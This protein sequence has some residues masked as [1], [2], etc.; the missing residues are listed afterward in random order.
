MTTAAGSIELALADIGAFLASRSERKIIQL[1]HVS[2]ESRHARILRGRIFHGKRESSLLS[3]IP[4]RLS[5]QN[6]LDGRLTDSFGRRKGECRV[7]ARKFLSRI[8]SGQ[9]RIRGESRAREAA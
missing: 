8:R 7:P 4:A 5:P 1:E 3:K 6:A 9:M 2:L